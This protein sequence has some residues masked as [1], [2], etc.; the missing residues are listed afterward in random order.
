MG[1]QPFQQPGQISEIIFPAGPHTFFFVLIKANKQACYS[2]D[3]IVASQQVRSWS[4]A[5]PV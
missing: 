4:N 2:F 3:H 1:G 5:C